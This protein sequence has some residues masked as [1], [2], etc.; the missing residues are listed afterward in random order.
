[1]E[2]K[3]TARNATN[4]QCYLTTFEIDEAENEENN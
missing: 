1:M 2:I 4:G 3:A